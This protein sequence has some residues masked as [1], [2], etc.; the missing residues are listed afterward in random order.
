VQLGA[1]D[2]ERV[3]VVKGLAEGEKVVTRANFLVDSESRL[4][5]SLAAM[6]G[7]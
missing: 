2:G 1:R 6:A 7:K 5:A 4:R 3:E